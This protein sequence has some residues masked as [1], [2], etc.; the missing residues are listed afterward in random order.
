[1]ILN[2]RNF[3]QNNI[4]QPEEL[5]DKITLVL[6]TSLTI[7]FQFPTLIIKYINRYKRKISL[8]HPSLL[9]EQLKLSSKQDELLPQR[10]SVFWQSHS[11]WVGSPAGLGSGLPRVLQLLFPAGWLA[12][13]VT[14]CSL[15]VHHPGNSWLPLFLATFNYFYS[16]FFWV[17][18]FHSTGAFEKNPNLAIEFKMKV[19]F[20][21]AIRRQNAQAER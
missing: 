14:S 13:A 20:R 6:N 7:S 18:F 3:K 12:Q 9:H 21:H 19:H 17:F 4:A 15:Q 16:L 2:G 5:R 8:F 10:P 11:H 1:M